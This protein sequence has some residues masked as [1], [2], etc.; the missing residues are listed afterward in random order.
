[1]RRLAADLPRALAAVKQ[2]R[3]RRAFG[4]N[5]CSDFRIFEK[6]AYCKTKAMAG[7]Q[8]APVLLLFDH[9]RHVVFFDF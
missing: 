1:L 7:C 4:I 6:Y 8:D 3:R 2:S 5:E 9:T